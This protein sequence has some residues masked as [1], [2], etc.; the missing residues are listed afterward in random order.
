M[1]KIVSAGVAVLALAFSVNA[2]AGVACTLIGE[3]SQ[4]GKST[5]FS[6]AVDVDRSK[7]GFTLNGQASDRYGEAKVNGNCN[8]NTK[9][10]MFTKEYVSGRSRGSKFYYAGDAANDV[11]TG[12]WGYRKGSYTGG[13]FTAQLLNCAN[14]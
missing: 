2:F 9:V 1:K 7:H 3:F 10:C 12:K 8:E 13:E 11:M 14:Q 4:G 6:W 5:E